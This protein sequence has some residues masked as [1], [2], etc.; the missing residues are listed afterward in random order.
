MKNIFCLII[1]AIGLFSCNKDDSKLSDAQYNVN[2][3]SFIDFKLQDSN[4]NNLLS[5][6]T[7]NY[8]TYESIDVIFFENGK[9]KVY[10][11][12]LLDAS[13]GYLILGDGA[14]K[15]IR[16]YLS[17]QI[18]KNNESLT[19]LRIEKSD[20]DT[21]KSSFITSSGKSGNYG[22][23]STSV[24][25]VWYNGNLILDKAAGIASELPI[26]RK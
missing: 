10:N 23:G 16:L 3:E 8:L 19:Y 20:L 17:L 18:D 25:N 26:I 12:P 21:L 24:Q 6:N 11:N 9:E 13:K 14:D 1:S 7:T 2:I 22:G 5:E 4:G 15:Y